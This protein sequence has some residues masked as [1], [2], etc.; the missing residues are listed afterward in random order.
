LRIREAE[1]SPMLVMSE[2]QRAMTVD[3]LMRA[4]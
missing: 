3:A 4:S 2:G 1:I